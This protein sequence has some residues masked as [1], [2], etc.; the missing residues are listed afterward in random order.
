MRCALA[1]I[2]SL[3]LRLMRVLLCRALMR[4]CCREG[5]CQTNPTNLVAGKLGRLAPLAYVACGGE[6]EV[7]EQQDSTMATLRMLTEF[8][9]E[10]NE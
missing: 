4:A 1:A 7:L 6:I 9:S 8:N 3:R 2:F 5:S 10:L